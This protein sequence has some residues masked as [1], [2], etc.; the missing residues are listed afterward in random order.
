MFV[1]LGLLFTWCLL[2]VC[3]NSTCEMFSERCN[4]LLI[5]QNSAKKNIRQFSGF[6]FSP[7]SDK[8]KK[9]IDQLT[10]YECAVSVV[11]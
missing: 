4:K 2:A 8:K 6:T 1:Y 3:C 9:K 7:D 11:L 10:K 5:V